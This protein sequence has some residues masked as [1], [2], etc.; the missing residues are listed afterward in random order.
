MNGA[1]MTGEVSDEIKKNVGDKPMSV[2]L[3]SR[4]SFAMAYT[5]GQKLLYLPSYLESKK[6]QI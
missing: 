1:L 2:V 5:C 4:F 6:K 3:S